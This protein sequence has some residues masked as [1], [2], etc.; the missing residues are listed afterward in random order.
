MRT[1][2]RS[3]SEGTVRR[4][5]VIVGYIPRLGE[6]GK[7]GSLLLALRDEAGAFHF[8]GTVRKGFPGMTRVRLGH[9]LERA[10]V[11][12]APVAQA[13]WLGNLERWAVPELVAEIEFFHDIAGQG[14]FRTPSFRGLRTDK[15][16]CDCVRDAGA[17]GPHCVP[18][19]RVLMFELAA[20]ACL[21]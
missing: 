14:R 7:V 8:A 4:H 20:F 3:L 2:S 6:L 13:P 5:F 11:D 12:A 10:H 1:F 15:T 17:E 21:Y 9:R 19:S 16:P 18:A